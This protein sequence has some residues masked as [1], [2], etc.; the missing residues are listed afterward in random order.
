MFFI[1]IV[2]KPT[3]VAKMRKYIAFFV[4]HKARACTNLGLGV[5]FMVLV[6]S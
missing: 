2:N 6:V 5:F 4:L 1:S 3:E